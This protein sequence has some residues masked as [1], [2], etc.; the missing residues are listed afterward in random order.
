VR[1]LVAGLGAF[2]VPQERACV[3]VH[4]C[5]HVS[6]C[7]R[8]FC[9]LHSEPNHPQIDMRPVFDAAHPDRPDAL[10]A[11]KRA[12]RDAGY[13]YAAN[14]PGLDVEYMQSVYTLSSAA[15]SLPLDVK[16][17]FVH[18]Q[19]TYSGAHC[20]CHSER[21]DGQPLL[22]SLRRRR[23]RRARRARVRE[24]YRLGGPR[25]GL[26]AYALYW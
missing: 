13:F 23:G 11:M 5:V 15:H 18:P 16:R 1:C 14:M 9:S 2:F 3:Q 19:G 20:R 26:L 10:R 25:M 17:R 12:M 6:R 24:R 4:A 8:G 7:T 22:S 21:A